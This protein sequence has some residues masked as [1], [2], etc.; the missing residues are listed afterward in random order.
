MYSPGLYNPTTRRNLIKKNLQA[1]IEEFK[2]RKINGRPYHPQ[3]QGRVERFIK[4]V[5][6]YFKVK[7]VSNSKWVVDLFHLSKSRINKA[8]KH[9][10]VLTVVGRPNL[11]I[12]TQEIVLYVNLIWEDKRFFGD[13]THGH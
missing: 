12:P 2:I 4:I 10:P 13:G 8:K 1:L 6:E 5:V 3:S 9:L 7:L 11:A